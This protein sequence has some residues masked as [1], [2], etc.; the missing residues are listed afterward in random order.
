MTNRD[1]GPMLGDIPGPIR[2]ILAKNVRRERVGAG[3]SQ[4]ELAERCQVRR[5]T[6]ARIEKAVQEPRLSTLVAFS[7]AMGIPLATLMT[8][9][10]DPPPSDG[11]ARP[12]GT[13]K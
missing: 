10:L 7:D 6:V 2:E 1:V 13:A 5:S 11:R 4:E 9:L 3:L 12:P 8:G